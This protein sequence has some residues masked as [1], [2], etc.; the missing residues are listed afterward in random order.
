MGGNSNGIDAHNKHEQSKGFARATPAELKKPLA[1]LI[2]DL[3]GSDRLEHFL[4]PVRF[5]SSLSSE[6]PRT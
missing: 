2:V 3:I 4:E 5:A 6:T 1:A